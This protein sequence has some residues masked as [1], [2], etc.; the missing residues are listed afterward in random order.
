MYASAIAGVPLAPGDWS[1]TVPWISTGEF[2]PV[3][4]GL[5]VTSVAV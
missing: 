3:T 2:V 4:A 5:T 1:V